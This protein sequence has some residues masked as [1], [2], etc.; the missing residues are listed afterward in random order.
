MNATVP[1]SPSFLSTDR[2]YQ[3]PVRAAIPRRIHALDATRRARFAIMGKVEKM[4][5]V[6]EDLD[7]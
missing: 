6:W 1:S 7:R 5:P 3:D 4:D 2:Y